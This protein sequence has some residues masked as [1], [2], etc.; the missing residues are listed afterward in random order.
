MRC[1]IRRSICGSVQRFQNGSFSTANGKRVLRAMLFD[2][3]E[4][5]SGCIVHVNLVD[6]GVADAGMECSTV[7]QRRPPSG[8]VSAL[9]RD[10]NKLRWPLPDA[11]GL[12]FHTS[13]SCTWN[14]TV[15]WSRWWRDHVIVQPWLSLK[16]TGKSTGALG[17]E[18]TE[19]VPCIACRRH[20][21]TTSSSRR[22][23]SASEGR[24]E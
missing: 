6:C 22:I 11:R 14:A 12:S 21:G 2:S 17:L 20:R 8:L 3:L 23:F 1:A 13:A 16:D 10:T 9:V 7:H 15:E 24:N 4:T 19:N 5:F 18:C